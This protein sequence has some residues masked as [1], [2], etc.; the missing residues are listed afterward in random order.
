MLPPPRVYLL[1][2]IIIT[3]SEFATSFL[4][5]LFVRSREVLLRREA[6]ICTSNV[7]NS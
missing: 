4:I 7:T 2:R 1:P 6:V 5:I 3:V